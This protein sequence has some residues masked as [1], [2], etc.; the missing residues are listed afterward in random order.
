[1]VEQQL[2]T[3][4]KTKQNWED[5]K[6]SGETTDLPRQSESPRRGEKTMQQTRMCQE[7][8]LLADDKYMGKMSE[9]KYI[10]DQSLIC[11]VLSLY[12]GSFIPV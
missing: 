11:A 9:N 2:R 5:R 7:E 8:L 1:M 6:Q 3:E 4:S 12:T 10:I